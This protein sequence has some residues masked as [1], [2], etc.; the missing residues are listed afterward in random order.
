[1]RY[2]LLVILINI[3]LIN[4]FFDIQYKLKCLY[5]LIQR[6]FQCLFFTVLVKEEFLKAELLHKYFDYVWLYTGSES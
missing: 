1:M 5:N 2:M 3:L 6:W 4:Y